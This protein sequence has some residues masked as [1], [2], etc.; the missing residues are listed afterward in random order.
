MVG[1]GDEGVIVH[2]GFDVV[3]ECG[4]GGGSLVR[5]RQE[6]VEGVVRDDTEDSVAH[7]GDG[8]EQPLVVV[9]TTVENGKGEPGVDEGL[10]AEEAHAEGEGRDHL[11]LGVVAATSEASRIR[12]V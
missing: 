10:A 3:S 9:Q 7:E 11:S 6:R 2:V 4:D 12:V 8:T 1:V 5:V